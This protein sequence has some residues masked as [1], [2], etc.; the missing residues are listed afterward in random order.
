[1]KKTLKSAISLILAI[2]TIVSLFAT[3]SITASAVEEGHVTNPTVLK[4]GKF[5]YK[6]WDAFNWDDDHY[7]KIIIPEDGYI[8]FTISKP[9]DPDDNELCSYELYMYDTSNNLVWQCA[10]DNTVDVFNNYYTYKIGL[11]AGTYYLNVC[12]GNFYI[13]AGDPSVTAH[14]KYTFTA[15][16]SFESGGSVPLSDKAYLSGSSAQM[17]L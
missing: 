2:L 16:D 8:T 1:M 15:H 4:N 7:N 12:P 11:H 13:S 3:G 14:Y 6:T 9:V 17:R 5:Y 10:R